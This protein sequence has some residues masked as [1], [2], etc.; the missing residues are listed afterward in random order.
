M[1]G[2][3]AF[4]ILSLP[5]AARQDIVY[6]DR[7]L[8][9]AAVVL[10]S[11]PAKVAAGVS[12]P[13][14]VASVFAPQSGSGE[15]GNGEPKGDHNDDGHADNGKGGGGGNDNVKPPEPTLDGGE[16]VL[17]HEFAEGLN[18]WEHQNALTARSLGPIEA[19]P[20]QS[21]DGVFA[22][23]HTGTFDDSFNTWV[24]GAPPVTQG[25]IE[26][27]VSVPLA[28]T[29]SFNM[30]YN[31]VSAEYP[32]W[33]GTE[34]NDYFSVTLSGPSG[35]KTLTKAEFL[36]S[37][38]FNSVT[39]LPEWMDTWVPGEGG[40]TGWKLYNQGALPLKS[41]IYKV[42]IEVNDVGD[43]IVTS[44]ILVDRVSLR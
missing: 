37:T 20:A 35:E 38:S 4:L 22:I 16:L 6:S 25:F 17:N 10:I 30:L 2:L 31:F 36:N 43:D 39:N 11:K 26:Q 44:A 9:G 19:D 8:S 15:T 13:V 42:R 18:H 5:A 33:Q 14:G 41:G 23:A 28:R 29:A 34:Y 24:L 40:Q 12:A 21:A 7:A 3:L 27:S 1:Q 32:E